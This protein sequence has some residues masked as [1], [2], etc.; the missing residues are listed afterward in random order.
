MNHRD[1]FLALI[2]ELERVL[3]DEA[4]HRG[5][6]P[7]WVERERRALANAA[8]AWA[9]AHGPLR[10]VTVDEIEQ[11]EPRAIGHSD[12]ARKLALYIAELVYEVE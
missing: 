4:R 7:D 2:D 8:N 6:R 9:V 10:T 5:D 1:R 12:Y 11:V 3:V